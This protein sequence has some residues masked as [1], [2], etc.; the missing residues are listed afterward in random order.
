LEHMASGAI[1]R[2]FILNR[3]GRHGF[4]ML[5]CFF[6]YFFIGLIRSQIPLL[7]F[8]EIFFLDIRSIK[9][10]ILFIAEISRSKAILTIKT[11]FQKITINRI[12]N[13]ASISYTAAIFVRM[14]AIIAKLA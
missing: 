6:L 8:L 7:D 12:N 5:L 3:F 13:L 4:P 14:H 2:H 10:I 1:N 9:N 11:I